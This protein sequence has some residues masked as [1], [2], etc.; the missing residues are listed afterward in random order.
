MSWLTPFEKKNHFLNILS[1]K[2]IKRI[3][4]KKSRR[5]I[6][7]KKLRKFKLKDPNWL[8]HKNLE[9]WVRYSYYYFKELLTFKLAANLLTIW[10]KY[11]NFK[12]IIKEK[13][14]LFVYLFF[15]FFVK[16]NLK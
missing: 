10:L 5:L 9:K 7:V 12:K 4:L 8:G 16:I 14:I 6:F 1:I 13:K 2:L 11:L 3:I 15:F